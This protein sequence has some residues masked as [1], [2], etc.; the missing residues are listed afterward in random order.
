MS[1]FYKLKWPDN[2]QCWSKSN[3]GSGNVSSVLK[4]NI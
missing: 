1:N 4:S 2:E 3:H